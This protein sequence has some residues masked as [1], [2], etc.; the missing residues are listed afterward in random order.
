MNS[1][2]IIVMLVCGQPDTV[3]VKYPDKQSVFSHN[4][5]SP[6][7]MKDIADIL[8]SEHVLITYEDERSICA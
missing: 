4:L 6:A 1:I 2:I 8:S 7:I 5:R 3:I